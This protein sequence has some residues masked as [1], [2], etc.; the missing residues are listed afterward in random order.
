[1]A[2]CQDVQMWMTRNILV[3]VSKAITDARQSCQEVGRWVDEQVTRP[4]ESWISRTER[5]CRDWPWPLSWICQAVVLVIKVVEWVVETVAKWVVTIVCQVVTFVIGWIVELVVRVIA[6]VVT[7]V[8]CLVT[9]FVGA[10][11]SIYDLW[12]ILI[13]AV[14]DIIDFVGVVLDDVRGILDDFDRLI[15]SLASSLGWLGVVLG[16]IKGV[17]NLAKKLVDIVKD[18]VKAAGDIVVGILTLNPCAI[19]R[20]LADLGTSIG[21]VVVEGAAPIVGAGVGVVAGGVPGAIA[22]A[23]L[24]AAAKAVGVFASGIRDSVVLR[25]LEDIATNAINLAFGAGSARATRAITS[26]NMRSRLFGIPFM[27]DARRMFLSS[28]SRVI[29]LVTLHNSG[30]IN[31]HG[32]AGYIGSCSKLF[33]E[34]DSEVVYAGT[35]LRV[36]YSD[37]DTFLMSGPGSVPEFRV[38]PIKKT[39]FLD[40]LKLAQRKARFLGAQLNMPIIGEFECTVPVWF[41]ME[42]ALGVSATQR[43]LLS[44]VFGRIAAVTENLSALPAVS[45]FHYMPNAA[46]KEFFGLTSW[47]RPSG[48]VAVPA[49]D[50]ESI[51][52][53]SGVTYRNLSP[54]YVFR[55]VLI[56]EIGHYLGLD[57]EDGTRWLDEIMYSVASGGSVSA[58]GIAEYLALGGEP[59]FTLGDANAAWRWFTGDGATAL[60]P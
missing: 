13:D 57:H 30:A 3:P 34:V 11:K 31:L 58:S 9:D 47:M 22:G 32:L 38:Y 26:L 45:H 40:H 15:D 10:L 8:V 18:V 37:I 43:G 39:K 1:V 27:P 53:E 41:P 52:M 2:A 35:N 12:N 28:N 14:S 49:G 36:S 59:R 21:R 20:G 55:F 19:L 23:G 29:N 56:H 25:Q 51:A 60:F 7:F 33:N 4:V 54:D 44:S 42:N 6:W 17:I 46:G 24:G 16:I 48:T 5:R 50:R